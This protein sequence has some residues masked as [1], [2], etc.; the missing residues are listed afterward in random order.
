MLKEMKLTIMGSLTKSLSLVLPGI[1]NLKYSSLI[2][3]SL[4]VITER[5]RTSST[6]WKSNTTNDYG[7][8]TCSSLHTRLSK[9]IICLIHVKR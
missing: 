4:T 8:M 3:I 7:D 2:V 9:C 5:G 1:R 6:W